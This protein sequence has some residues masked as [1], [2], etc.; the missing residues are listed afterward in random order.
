[1][2][3]REAIVRRFINAWNMRDTAAIRAALHP[4]IECVGASYPAARGP[5]ETMA[6]SAPFLAA[7]EIDWRIIHCATTGPVV[8]VERIDRFRFG[9]RP[10]L[11]IPACGVFDIADDGLIRR[12]FDYFDSCG[13]AEAMP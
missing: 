10:W 1:M 7:D 13:L 4:E 11:V 2:I 12:W 9:D 8:F 6:L 3:D 5:D